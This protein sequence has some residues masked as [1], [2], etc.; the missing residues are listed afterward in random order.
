MWTD[1]AIKKGYRYRMT[2]AL[3]AAEMSTRG[4]LKS[5]DGG[6]FRAVGF[7]VNCPVVYRIN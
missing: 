6:D 1:E 5:L 4:Y 2:S 7:V 3:Q